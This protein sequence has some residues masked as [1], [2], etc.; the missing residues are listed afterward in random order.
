LKL[1][2]LFGDNMLIEFLSLVPGFFSVVSAI[3]LSPLAKHRRVLVS[4]D[5]QDAPWC[6]F[7]FALSYLR[8]TNPGDIFSSTD[9]TGLDISSAKFQE[10]SPK[11][12]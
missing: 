6:S 2:S 3:F 4:V 5:V 11:R 8:S 12:E 7:I 9:V 10:S 1:A